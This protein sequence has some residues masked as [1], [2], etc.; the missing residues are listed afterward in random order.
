MQVCNPP[1]ICQSQCSYAR[2][3]QDI[4][5]LAFCS[6]KTPRSTYKSQIY[7]FLFSL[8]QNFQIHK[9][10]KWKFLSP[11]RQKDFLKS[12][13][14]F[15]IFRLAQNRWCFMFGRKTDRFL[16]K[17]LQKT[18]LY[19]HEKLQRNPSVGRGL[20]FV[21]FRPYGFENLEFLTTVR[22]GA[23][24]SKTQWVFYRDLDWWPGPQKVQCR[25]ITGFPW[26][27]ELFLALLNGWP[28]KVLLLDSVSSERYTCTTTVQ[29]LRFKID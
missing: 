22:R 4:F 15:Q 24:R 1:K 5:K 2:H 26:V 7:Y 13:F 23:M 12:K 17:S 9:V 20:K 10:E 25:E 8:F 16:A 6:K 29:L 3:L 28:H 14:F 18:C 19:V 11:F 27:V 21:I